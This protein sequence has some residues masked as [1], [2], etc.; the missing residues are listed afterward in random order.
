[1]RGTKTVTR[2]SHIALAL[3]LLLA[4]ARSAWADAPQEV[5]AAQEGASHASHQD[6]PLDAEQVRAMVKRAIALQHQSDEALDEYDRTERIVD[7]DRDQKSTETTSRVVPVGT[8][9]MRVEMERNGQ[10]ATPAE[11]AQAWRNVA[12]TLESRSHSGD[13]QVK[14]DYERAA[15]RRRE[16][17]RMVDAIGEAFRFRWARRTMR[18]GRAV[19]ELDFEPQPGFKPSMRFAGVYKQ[20]WGKVWV[21]ES[22][23]YVV[24]LEAELRRDIPIGGGIVGKVY[25]GSRIEIEQAEAAPGVWLPT[26][27]S[28]DIEGRK[29]IFPASLHRKLYASGYR[30]IGPPAEALALIRSEHAQLI[31][32]NP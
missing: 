1:M 12:G 23:G 24:R 27:N 21:D 14:K 31:T 29:F 10:P 4:A 25:R 32:P 18:E 19:V 17:A 9:A 22:S 7:R 5:L 30:R 8:G 3:L 26:F 28:Y 6:A 20:I 13:P 2:R 11:I 16:S 15:K